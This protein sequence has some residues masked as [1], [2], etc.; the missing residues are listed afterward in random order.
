MD[1]RWGLAVLIGFGA[2]VVLIGLLVRFVAWS[3]AARVP[4]GPATPDLMDTPP[5]V[6]NL[7][8]NGL[9]AAPEA[10]AAT[11]LDLAARGHLELDQPTADP[12]ATVVRVRRGGHAGLTSYEQR[13]LDRVDVAPGVRPLTLADLARRH[14]RDGQSWHERLVIAVREEAIAHGLIRV[15]TTPPAMVVLIVGLML[16][17]ILSCVPGV[18]VIDLVGMTDRLGSTGVGIGVLGV[19]FVLMMIAIF[20]VVQLGGEIRDDRLT[21]A[22]RRVARHW[23]GVGRWLRS[24]E[25]FA[26]LPPA[27]V[28]VW[29]SY[30]AHG[31]ALGAA[32]RAAA[33]VDLRVGRVDVVRSSPGDRLV[34]IR[35]PAT[36]GLKATSAGTRVV[37]ALIGI[38]LAAAVALAAATREPPGW[39][40][41]SAVA[42]AVL[43]S[44]RWVYRIVRGLTDLL[45]PAS[46]SGRV[47]RIVPFGTFGDAETTP[48]LTS[49]YQS[50][51]LSWLTRRV[52]APTVTSDGTGL[53][54]GF[55]VVLDD[56]TSAVAQAWLATP[57]RA[58]RLRLG[59]DVTARVQPWT[60]HLIS[61]SP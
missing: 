40:A 16:L 17:L 42:V 26:D 41:T 12:G 35:Y 30:L 8:M 10:A 2:V 9:R 34:R 61:S 58:G 47:L 44:L 25:A 31:V 54:P 36:G 15:G 45:R 52:G 39:A 20:I 5:A 38:A 55:F 18:F 27:S 28:T 22:G 53:S 48:L 1:Y 3:T 50:P 6:V 60:R 32:T 19:A 33:T 7:L 21:A 46:V 24:H 51:L 11:L 23:A 29:D 49:L 13:V 57:R 14:A 43:L 4:A 37:G 59:D 56:G